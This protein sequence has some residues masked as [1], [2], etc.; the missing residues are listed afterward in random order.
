MITLGQGITVG[1]GI[2]IGD[3]PVAF[4][5]FF[6]TEDGNNYLITQD[7]NNNFVELIYA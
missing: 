6:V 2:Q 7:N 5:Y 3:A 4:T 1:Q